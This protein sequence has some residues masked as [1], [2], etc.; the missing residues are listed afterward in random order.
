M[1]RKA[2]TLLLPSTLLLAAALMS[3]NKKCAT[4]DGAGLS[5]WLGKTQ[6][7]AP[8][9]FTPA[10]NDGIND[11]F[12]FYMVDS[13]PDTNAQLGPVQKIKDLGMEI[14]RGGMLLYEAHGWGSTWNG[15][16]KTGKRVDGLVDVAYSIS[17]MDGNVSEGSF[18]LFVV[19]SGDC[20][21]ECMRDHIFGDMVDPYA[22]VSK[23]TK[24]EFCQ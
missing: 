24:E 17:D 10:N 7:I 8:T 5:V 23:P 19:P 12:G 11:T 20:L 15:K 9:A 1:K 3:C 21:Q 16:S 2:T 6:I 14:T 18:K 4:P 22:G 13:P